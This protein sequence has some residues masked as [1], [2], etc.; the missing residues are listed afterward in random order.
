MLLSVRCEQPFVLAV[1]LLIVIACIALRIV[2]Y[3]PPTYRYS[4]AHVCRARGMMQ[5]HAPSIFLFF[6]RVLILGALAFLIAR[7]QYGDS[8]QHISVDGIQIVLALDVSGS[9]Q[10][11]D[12]DDDNRSRI[13]VAKSEAIRFI[14]KRDNDAIGLVIFGNDALSRCPLTLDKTLL[15]KIVEELHLGII[16]PQGTVLARGIVAGANRLKHASAKS[17]IMIVLTDG[18]PSEND[19]AMNDAIAIAKQLGIKLYTIGIGSEEVRYVMHPFYGRVPLPSVNKELLTRIA[20]ET[21]GHYFLAR[22]AADMRLIYD[23]IDKLEKTSYEAPVFTSWHDVYLPV[24]LCILMLM[25]IE[26]MATTFIWR[27]L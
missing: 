16:D 17:K 24:V 2:W 3:K 9:M 1:F 27:I 11:Q 10:Y 20:R 5:M 12:F 25:F 7:L 18:E 4:L 14:E 13:D 6:I 26:Y 21:G 19:L 15:K 22:N 23:E 8:K